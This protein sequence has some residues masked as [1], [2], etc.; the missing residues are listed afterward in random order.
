M[1]RR[2][3]P[4]L[5]AASGLLVA[6][7][8]AAFLLRPRREVTTCSDEAYEHYKV[9]RENDLKL[10]D[11][12]AVDAY[13]KALLEDPQFVMATLRLAGKLRGKDPERARALLKGAERAMS[14]VTPREALFVKIFRAQLD[15]DPAIDALLDEY[16]KTFPEDPE[17]YHLRSERLF[18]GGRSEE[19]VAELQRLLALDPNQAWAYN[20]LGYYHA[21]LEQYDKAEEQFLKYRFLAPDQANPYDSLG[22]LYAFIGRYDEAEKQLRS[23]L[24]KKRDFYP[25]HGHLGTVYV[26]RGEYLKA[27]ESFRRVVELA[28]APFQKFEFSTYVVACL[29]LAGQA[30]PALE[31]LTKGISNVRAAGV[32]DP[33]RVAIELAQGRALVFMLT[34][35]LDEGEGAL[36]ELDA[37]LESST[38]L[39]GW[40]TA[41][42]KRNALTISASIAARRGRLED[43]AESFQKLFEDDAS[44]RTKG[45]PYFD[46]LALVRSA[47]ADVLHRLGR[48]AEA[49]KLLQPL[50]ERNPRFFAATEVLKGL[51]GKEAKG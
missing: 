34:S 4:L 30:E 38:G 7:T 37:L 25:G 21:A 42:V 19:G 9:G 28:D 48:D 23:A 44:Y 12:E 8:A 10:Y 27:A 24:E 6:G 31:E 45:F 35:R 17:G 26:G 32:L 33:A 5:L 29:A 36:A 11:R 49:R 46:H 41:S 47:Y 15:R 50:L 3:I 18:S 1:L 51:G 16:V 13:A 14:E 39:P 20:S 2:R 40:W 22:E 43:A